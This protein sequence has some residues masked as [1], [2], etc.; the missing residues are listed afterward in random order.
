MI[1]QDEEWIKYIV[2][3]GW[4]GGMLFLERNPNEMIDNNRKQAFIHQVDAK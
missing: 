1:A 3:V 4:S 2:K